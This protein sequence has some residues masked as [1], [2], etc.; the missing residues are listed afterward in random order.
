MVKIH[1][2]FRIKTIWKKIQEIN[3]CNFKTF[4][5]RQRQEPDKTDPQSISLIYL[6]KTT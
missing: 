5:K 1:A 2:T 6:K 3:N 4:I